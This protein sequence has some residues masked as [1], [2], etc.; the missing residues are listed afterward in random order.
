MEVVAKDNLLAI[1]RLL[2]RPHAK[3]ARAR[4]AIRHQQGIS[5][6]H[7][8]IRYPRMPGNTAPLIKRL[9]HG[10]VLVGWAGGATDTRTVTEFKC[11]PAA[12]PWAST[13]DATTG[14]A[15]DIVMRAALRDVAAPCRSLGTAVASAL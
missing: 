13:P 10:G 1:W 12:W 2:T 15:V 9:G 4:T 14:P 11:L 8:G 7:Q 3:A 5:I 6:S